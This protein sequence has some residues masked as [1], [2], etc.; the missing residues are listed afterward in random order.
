MINLLKELFEERRIVELMTDEVACS[1]YNVDN[2]NE[3]LF[4]LDEEIQIE[5]R[6]FDGNKEL[7][8]EEE[9]ENEYWYRL[10][11]ESRGW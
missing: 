9:E 8:I 7:T 6:S 5:Q 11:Y 2:K 10:S 3:I 4:L 1:M